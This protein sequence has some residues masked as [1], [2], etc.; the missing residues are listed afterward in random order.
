MGQYLK[1][2]IIVTLVLS[3]LSLIA[4]ATE[5]IKKDKKSKNE[6]KEI[7]KSTSVIKTDKRPPKEIEPVTCFGLTI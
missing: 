4:F 3:A 5:T 2:K 1:M 7:K 6:L